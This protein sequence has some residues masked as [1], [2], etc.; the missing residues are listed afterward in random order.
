MKFFTPNKTSLLQQLYIVSGYLAP[1][2]AAIIIAACLNWWRLELLQRRIFAQRSL[3]YFIVILSLWYLGKYCYKRLT[4]R[5]RFTDFW[6]INFLEAADQLFF[7]F[8]LFFLIVI[9]KNELYNFI[10]TV[11]AIASLYFTLDRFFDKHHNAKG[12][13]AINNL[14]F[15]LGGFIFFTSSIF[16]YFT[17][18]YY[19]LESKYE[20][21]AVDYAV[22]LRSLA[23]T[24]FWLSAFSVINLIN[25]RLKNW[26]KT[27]FTI[28]AIIIFCL[29]QFIWIINIGLLHFSGLLLSPV[30]LQYANGSSGLLGDAFFISLAL[31][32]GAIYLFLY[33]IIR[34]TIK[35]RKSSPAKYWHFYHAPILVMTILIALALP[36]YKN[37]PEYLIAKTFYGHYTEDTK[38]AVTIDPKIFDKLERF[39][40]MYDRQNLTTY[41]SNIFAPDSALPQ[42]NSNNTKPNVIIFFLESFSARLTSVYN[43]PKVPG[44]TPG[45]ETMAKDPQ[46]TVFKKFYNASTPTITGI[47]SEL[48][49]FLPPTGH[50]D[51]QKT[52]SYKSMRFSCLP[53][54]AKKH[55]NYTSAT[56]MTSVDKNYSDKDKIVGGMAVDEVIGKQE[57]AQLISEKPLSWGYSDHQT[58]PLLLAMAEK[59]PQPFIMMLSTV[60]SHP[61]FDIAKD[62][63]IYQN[64]KNNLLNS[65]HT[66]DDA[67][68]R[69][70][71]DFKKSPLANNTVIVTVADHAIFPSVY[72]NKENKFLL[73]SVDQKITFYDEIVFMVYSPYTQLPRTIEMYSSGIDFAPTILHILNINSP[74]LFEGRSIFDDQKKYPNILGMNEYEIYINQTKN[75]GTR[76]MQ[77]GAPARIT[78]SY[79]FDA[80]MLTPYDYAQ[81]Y[82]WKKKY[83]AE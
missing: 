77:Y 28:G 6:R 42:I 78:D 9:P 47:L 65:V 15:T 31:A 70:W 69:F 30:M 43:N 5:N 40:L 82:N 48:C 11:I 81:Y 66:T 75:D 55:G 23:M 51:I 52:Q 67:F 16:Q 37:T 79:Q 73:D 3:L 25:L 61:P 58:M 14:I 39:G 4:H 12:W 72:D 49:S 64:G 10:L 22:A 46:T 13:H 41:R 68:L 60:D 21:G 20:S 2:F 74:T 57:V 76:D 56:Y 44:I 27:I 17:V 59:K 50:D 38:A 36:V 53:E 19:I 45:L 80:N 18:K 8:A 29:L 71:A 7:N 24:L 1:T 54:I 35:V 83:F 26:L 33:K 34:K 62:E 63:V 32:S